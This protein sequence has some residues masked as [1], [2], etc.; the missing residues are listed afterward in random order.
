MLIGLRLTD[1]NR[2]RI[3]ASLGARC[4]SPRFSTEVALPAG[5]GVFADTGTDTTRLP[6]GRRVRS[7]FRI[8]GT[9]DGAAASGTARVSNTVTAAGRRKRTCTSGTVRWSARRSTGD[10]GPAGVTPGV[11]MYG[12]TAQ[13][14]RGARR[15]I[16]LR[17]SADGARLERALYDITLKCPR[18][19]T[20]D[21]H[22]APRRNLAIAADGTFSDVERFRYRDARTIRYD[23]ERFSGTSAGA[24]G[25][26]SVVSRL[27]DRGTGRTISTCR[28]GTVSWTAAP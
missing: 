14:L 4:E 11:P 20:T 9:I 21:V 7:R 25:T 22:D 24:G 1:D 15:A 23:T 6:G 19:T 27:A 3:N 17:I 5:G 18:T 10:L 16:V 28:T 13:R 12:T 8:E 2:L 26:F